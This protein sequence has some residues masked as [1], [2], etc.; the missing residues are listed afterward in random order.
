MSTLTPS[1]PISPPGPVSVFCRKAG[2]EQEEYFRI[3][4]TDVL[5]SSY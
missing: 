2:G 3:T 4:L 1:I 5:V